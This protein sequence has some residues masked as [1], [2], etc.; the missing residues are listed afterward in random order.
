MPLLSLLLSKYVVLL[1]GSFFIDD[2]V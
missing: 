2:T 1:F